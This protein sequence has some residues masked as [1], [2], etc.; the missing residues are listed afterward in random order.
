MHPNWKN[1]NTGD[2]IKGKR[3]VPLLDSSYMIFFLVDENEHKP[4]TVSK[5]TIKI[6]FLKGDGVKICINFNKRNNVF[7]VSCQFSSQKFVTSV[8]R[9][10]LLHLNVFCILKT[11]VLRRTCRFPYN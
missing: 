10:N 5:V 4:S 7:T 3:Q 11:L 2:I 6:K 8:S 1:R 9:I